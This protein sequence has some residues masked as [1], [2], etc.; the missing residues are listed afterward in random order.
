MR[1]ALT[2]ALLNRL[3]PD[4][5][6]LFEPVQ[7]TM[8]GHPVWGESCT[9][10]RLAVRMIPDPKRVRLALEVQGVM[11][12]RTTSRAGPATFWS[13]TESRFTA[14]KRIELDLTGL[15][16]EPTRVAIEEN[17]IRLRGLA[18]SF[19]F[20]PV[21]GALAQEIALEQHAQQQPLMYDELD[22]K[23]AVRAQS[24]VDEETEARLRQFN[25]QLQER[26]LEP[27]AVL[28]LGPTL[29][30]AQTSAQRLTLRLRLGA[31][32]QLGGSGNRP[33]APADSLASCQVHESAV[34]NFIQSLNLDGAQLR[35]PELRARL[36]DALNWPELATR[37]S[38]N[39]D[40]EIRFAPENAA[41]VQFANGQVAVI[42]AIAKLRKS[43]HQWEDFQVRAVYRP[44]VQGR[45]A[46]LVREE[47]I[48]LSGD[49]SVRSQLALRT[50]FN[51]TFSKQRPWKLTPEAFETDPRF[52]KLA[53]TQLVIDDGW[54]GLALGPQRHGQQPA[55]AQR[56]EGDQAPSG[57][58]G[59]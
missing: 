35:L 14:V 43:P 51:K 10:S 6:D 23:V 38:E 48:Q 36:A 42:L 15:R 7:D 46:E 27:M 52:A 57:P 3:L 4:P 11:A 13:D 41:Q 47:L 56:V 39:D 58:S 33:W 2:D 37:Q 18:T 55:V 12:A 40:A 44:R 49:L 31:D 26:V 59:L 20:F 16:F 19:D 50:V 22:W 9:Q 30:G 29:V 5:K 32:E 25:K 28:G 21:L 24:R 54:L 53:I 1:I 17:D 8:L 34:N 45:T